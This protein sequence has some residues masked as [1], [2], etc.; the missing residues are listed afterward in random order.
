VDST[1]RLITPADSISSLTGLI[2]R[3][4]KVLGDMGF[5]YTGTYQDDA[6]TRERI[7]RGECYVML[8]SGNIVGTILLYPPPI[9]WATAGT[10]YARTKVA[11][12]GQFAVEPNLQRSGR[13]SKLMEVIEQRAAE[14]GATEL[15]LDTSEGATHLIRF[16]TNRGY[17]FVEHIHHEGKN[18]R[19]S[20]FSKTLV[21]NRSTV[22]G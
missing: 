5:N 1:I 3:A 11:C 17:R 4:Y 6:I 9:P 13:G 19:S 21:K 7:V 16:Y 15:A 20:V 14:L 18:Y 12:C 10:W 2:R 22:G 8:E